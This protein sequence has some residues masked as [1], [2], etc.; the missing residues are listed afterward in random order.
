MGHSDKIER[1]NKS[2][3]NDKNY[4][5]DFH[6]PKIHPECKSIQC[7]CKYWSVNPIQY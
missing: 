4:I 1:A 7:K 3:T 2:E 5:F 6:V